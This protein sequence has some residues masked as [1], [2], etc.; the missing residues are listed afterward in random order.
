MP[1]TERYEKIRNELLE[2]YKNTSNL[3]RKQKKKVRKLLQEKYENNE[4]F[5]KPLFYEP[6]V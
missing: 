2:Q 5:N 1:T 4:L 3:P 6:C